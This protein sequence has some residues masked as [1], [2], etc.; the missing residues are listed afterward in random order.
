MIF[1]AQR[2]LKGFTLIELLIV[3]AILGI[4]AA[5][6][7]IAINPTKRQ[8]QAKD[9]N[10]KSDIGSIALAMQSYYTN[11]GNGQYPTEAQGLAILVTNQDLKSLPTPPTGAG[12]AYVYRAVT[13]AGAACTNLSAAT[14]CAEVSIKAPMFD[15]L[16]AANDWC[17]K[18]INGR[19]VELLP[20]TCNTPET[21]P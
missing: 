14:N 7:L 15:P 5:A 1:T 17:W 3:I 18:S 16:V 21:N 19:A 4:L 13:T 10:I 2:K 9:A 6:V 11:P 20:A 12:A 8:N